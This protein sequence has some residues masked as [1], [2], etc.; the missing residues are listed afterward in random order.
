MVKNYTDSQLLNK[1]KSL[2]SFK[3]F[4][5][6]FWILGVQSQEDTFNVFDDTFYIF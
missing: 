2:P 6:D 4:P 1:V 5:N 3:Q